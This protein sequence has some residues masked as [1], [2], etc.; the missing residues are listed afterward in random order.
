[1]IK[2]KSII[3]VPRVYR[4]S[5]TKTQVSCR[6]IIFHG[7][8]LL[9]FSLLFQLI[10]SVSFGSAIK[11]SR[12]LTNLNCIALSTPKAKT[13]SKKVQTQDLVAKLRLNLTRLI[14]ALREGAPITLTESEL[15]LVREKIQYV[16]G[17]K[18][19]ITSPELDDLHLIYSELVM[20]FT[21]VDRKQF[22]LNAQDLEVFEELQL[23]LE[24]PRLTNSLIDLEGVAKYFNSRRRD[25][26]QRDQNLQ[27]T[28]IAFLYFQMIADLRTLLLVGLNNDFLDSSLKISEADFR[29]FIKGESRQLFMDDLALINKY[30]D[31]IFEQAEL[32]KLEKDLQAIAE[33]ETETSIQHAGIEPETHWGTL[34]EWYDT[35]GPQKD[36]RAIDRLSSN[37]WYDLRLDPAKAV[38]QHVSLRIRFTEDFK[39]EAKRMHNQFWPLFA[40][41]I[42]GRSTAGDG[43][44]ILSNSE[45][46]HS[47]EGNFKIIKIKRTGRSHYRFLGCLD[48]NSGE[49][50]LKTLVST[51]ETIDS[52]QN[53]IY[54]KIC[55]P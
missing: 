11:S 20:F 31:E 50:V 30:L 34:N 4:L 48:I 25:H 12:P 13:K 41:L 54:E 35:Y 16:F 51:P 18:L 1:M 49:V 46:Y 43:W 21:R 17:E 8:C 42:Q 40:K 53:S 3:T 10:P 6:S 52:T 5:P 39:R 22:L 55:P 9:S 7:L 29:V 37:H 45:R 26:Q 28:F 24:S 36:S 23:L 2:F 15:P 47:G 27:K 33:A 38:M 44:S 19:K 14:P 32:E